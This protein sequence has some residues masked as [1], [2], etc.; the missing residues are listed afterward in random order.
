MVKKTGVTLFMSTVCKIPVA[1]FV[2]GIEKIKRFRLFK[3]NP[4]FIDLNKSNDRKFRTPSNY[5]TPPNTYRPELN[6]LD[7]IAKKEQRKLPGKLRIKDNLTK[8]D[9]I[10]L[11]ELCMR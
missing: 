1:Q 9:R 5:S 4:S 7:I 10:A 2:F 6:E 11:K 8:A 3:I